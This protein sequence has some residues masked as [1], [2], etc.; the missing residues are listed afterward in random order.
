MIN[1][2]RI[3]FFINFSNRRVYVDHNGEVNS[4]NKGDQDNK[5]VLGGHVDQ[6]R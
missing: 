2:S 4:N 5:E 3:I 6:N 1:L